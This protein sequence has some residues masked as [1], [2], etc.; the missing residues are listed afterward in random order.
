MT[1]VANS[2][3]QRVVCSWV[4]GPMPTDDLTETELVVHLVQPRGHRVGA[5][6]HRVAVGEQVSV[7]EL[8]EG[9][10]AGHEHATQRAG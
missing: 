5:A 3:A 7:T 2:S 4:R 1:S 9:R 8:T 10:L 6:D